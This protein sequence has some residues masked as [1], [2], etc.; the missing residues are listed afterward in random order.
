[1][2]GEVVNESAVTDAGEDA[3]DL[4]GEIRQDVS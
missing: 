4:F 3:E 2:A 1:M